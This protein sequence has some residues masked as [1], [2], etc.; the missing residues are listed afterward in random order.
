M[1]RGRLACFGTL[2]VGALFT[3][4][5]FGQETEPVPAPEPPAA[6]VNANPISALDLDALSATREL[7]LFTPSRTPPIV[8]E[9]EPEPEPV[10]EPEIVE[11]TADPPPLELIGIVVTEAEQVVLLMDQS[12]GEVQRIRPGDDFQGW[13]VS[14]ID[15][16]T[17]ELESEGNSQTLTMFTGTGEEAQL[18]DGF[19]DDFGDEE[20]DAGADLEQPGE[21]ASGVEEESFEEESF[22]DESFEEEGILPEE[23]PEDAEIEEFDSVEDGLEG[24]EAPTVE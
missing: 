13:T 18:P 23:M 16:R 7:P 3:A 11:E 10:I 8:V 4:S 19:E 15:S 1:S 22:E 9:A 12:T 24:E 6:P 21:D 17:V 5:A 14:I 2:L 20:F